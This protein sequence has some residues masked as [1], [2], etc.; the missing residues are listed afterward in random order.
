LPEAALQRSGSRGKLVEIEDYG[1]V[2]DLDD[3]E[4]EEL[5]SATLVEEQLSAAPSSS[6]LS[7]ALTAEE[8]EEVRLALALPG[9]SSAHSLT[10]ASS[11]SG[12]EDSDGVLM[13]EGDGD[14]ED[15]VSVGLR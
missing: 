5:D 7:T 4:E 11:G 9:A 1:S 6:F 15:D 12:E 3:E 14:D 10:Y 2:T 8:L 13:D